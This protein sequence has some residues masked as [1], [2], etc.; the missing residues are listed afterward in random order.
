MMGF[1]LHWQIAFVLHM[2]REDE[3]VKSILRTRHAGI[4]SG[5]L[6]VCGLLVLNSNFRKPCS[7]CYFADQKQPLI[8][9]LRTIGRIRIITETLVTAS[10]VGNSTAS[11]FENKFENRFDRKFDTKFEKTFDS[12]FESRV[13]R[14]FYR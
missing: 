14:K 4:A 12:K 13:D 11:N 2:V 10:L 1:V 9:D 8:L 5:P 6:F 7:V 3:A